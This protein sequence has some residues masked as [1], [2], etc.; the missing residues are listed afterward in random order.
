MSAQGFRVSVVIPT[1]NR[2]EYLLEA[3]Q[4]VF[5]QTVL[6][7]EVVVVDDGSGDGSADAVRALDSPIPVQCIEQTN[8]G[9]G[10]AR[11]RGIGEA[12]GDWIAFHDSDDLWEPDKLE[13]QLEFVRSNPHLDWVFATMINFDEKS[14]AAAPEVLDK[15]F[16]RYCKEHAAKLDDLFIRLLGC[17]PIPTPTV[18]M[19]AEFCARVGDFRSDLP[20]SEDLD[21][22]LRCS[23]L[24]V[25]GF[26]DLPLLRRRLHPENTVG[27]RNLRL[28]TVIRVLEDM[29]DSVS[30]EGGQRNASAMLRAI[31]RQRYRLACDAYRA[32]DFTAARAWLTKVNPLH[33]GSI[34]QAVRWAVKS[35]HSVVRHPCTDRVAEL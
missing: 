1:F 7:M 2:R 14:K 20:C 15:A 30:A 3:L 5:Q 22:W 17:N 13:K 25:C 8:Q 11:S 29:F 31:H 33:L 12:N 21:Y 23:R 28:Q 10:A 4:S 35:I 19:R 27:D 6:P 26:Q 32:R 16:Y 9:P 18:L 24:G 34:D